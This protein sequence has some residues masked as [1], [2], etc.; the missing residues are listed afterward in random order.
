MRTRPLENLGLKLLSVVLAVFLW[1]VVLGEQ[2][3]DVTLTV[4]LEIKDLPRDLILVNEPPDSLEVRLRGPK[5]LVT[6]LASREVVLEGLPKNFVEGENVITIRS[7]A[8]RV[9]RG[10]EVVEVT[11]HRVRVVLDAMAVREVEVSPRIEGAPAKGFILKRVTSTPARIR[12]AGP[13]NELRRLTRVYTVPISLD[14]QTASFSTRAMLEPAGRQVRVLDE[15]PI[16]VGVE[17]AFRK[18]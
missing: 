1:A 7:E 2:K 14:G 8:V 5:T 13:K 6:T 4:P 10:I 17:I 18:S 9:P 16:I 11:P 12:M 3:V 15:V